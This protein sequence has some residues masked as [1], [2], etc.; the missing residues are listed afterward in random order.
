M[1]E[2][3][4][5]S[6][7][8]P[9]AQRLILTL[10]YLLVAASPFLLRVR[11]EREDGLLLVLFAL[12]LLAGLAGMRRPSKGWQR[13][14]APIRVD[15]DAPPLQGLTETHHPLGWASRPTLCCQRLIFATAIVFAYALG[16]RAWIVER[17]MQTESA[18][19]LLSFAGLF[20]LL[21]V[22]L[23]LP[24]GRVAWRRDEYR[25]VLVVVAVT[26]ALLMLLSLVMLVLLMGKYPPPQFNPAQTL[27]VCA[28]SLEYLGVF[29]VA[30]FPPLEAKP[31]RWTAVIVSLLLIVTAALSFRGGA[32]E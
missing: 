6:P 8:F 27:S 11:V 19:Q 28:Q 2:S 26:S 22:A 9:L 25:E 13:R 32:V 23:W 16:R 10:G 1:K 5:N 12:A 3:A 30:F 17:F 31:W 7:S 4:A 29:A 18:G 21:L 15:R 20:V 14:A 24:H